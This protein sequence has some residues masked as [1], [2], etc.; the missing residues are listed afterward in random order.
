LLEEYKDVFPAELPKGLPPARDVK[1]T[2]PLEEGSVP[3]FRGMYRVSPAELKEIETQVADLLEK[4]FIEPSSSPYGAP[5]LFVKKKDGTLR[6]VIDYRALNKITIKNKYPLPRID[7]LLDRLGGAKYF[8]SLDLTSGYHQIRINSDDVPKTAFRTPLGHFQFKVLSFGLTNAPA[9]FQ[10]VMNSVFAPLLGR[11]VVVYLDDILIYSKTAE[12]HFAHLRQVL[13]ILRHEKLF[14]KMKKCTFF[15]KETHFLGHVVGRDGIRADPAKIA[16]VQDWPVPQSA[17]HVRSFL[18]LTNYFRRF[19]QGYA[20]LTHP[21]TDLTGKM[22]LSCG[23]KNVSRH[24][25]SSKMH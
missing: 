17:S 12:E 5:V 24:S 25:S 7:D 3:P 4:G 13:Q 10:T 6:M 15:E 23:R 8:T 9:T 19:I 2:I 11:S 22:S 20:Q 18:G 1:H 16:A 14:A 21:L